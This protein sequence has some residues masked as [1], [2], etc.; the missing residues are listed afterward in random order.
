MQSA[1][2]QILQ[3]Y[4]GYPQF[5]P[6]QQS[7]IESV[8]QGKDVFGIMPTGGGKSLCYQVPALLLP[9]TALVV[10][11]LISLMEDQVHNLQEKG[12]PAVSI[13]S[14]LHTG[15]LNDIL[16]K[17]LSGFYKVMYCSPERLH[18]EAF[19]RFA[20]AMDWS[21]FVIDE[22]H[23]ISQW[24][25]D[26][27][28]LYRQ[29]K[30]FQTAYS[31]QSTLALTASATTQVQQDIIEQLQ[32]QNASIFHQSVVRENLSYHV[33]ATEH[34]FQPLVQ[35]LNHHNSIVYCP[36][37]K[38]TENIANQ[39][40]QHGQPAIAYHA[41]LPKKVRS[42]IQNQWITQ[43][44]TIICATNA[45]GMGIDKPNVREVIH[46]SPPTSLEAYYQEAGRAGRDGKLAQATL[47]FTQKDIK[48]LE[49]SI[50]HRFPPATFIQQCYNDIANHLEIGIGEGSGRKY[51]FSIEQF[52]HRYKHP[53]LP[54]MHA[55]KLLESEGYWVWQQD[56]RT[57]HS[58]VFTSRHADIEQLQDISSHLY[59]LAIQLLRIYGDIYRYYTKIDIATIARVFGSDY[60]SVQKGLIKLQQLGI[61]KYQP[62]QEGSSL[63]WFE[64]RLPPHA[65]QINAKRIVLLKEAYMR[66]IASI[67]NYLNNTTDCR[68][69]LI[70]Q[71]FGEDRPPSCGHCDNCLRDSKPSSNKNLKHEIH[72]YIKIALETDLKSITSAFSEVSIDLVLHYIQ[73]LSLEGYIKI[74]G[75]N[76]IFAK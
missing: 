67:L 15:E 29:I 55:I 8:L 39:L 50:H 24:G 18:S 54:L 46:W 35:S 70:A 23:C 9:G 52:N 69:Q 53:I 74:Q 65:F 45:F 25:H 49:E 40:S 62:A 72:A 41:G 37:R 4:W 16:Q 22:A 13:H 58:A 31:F 10:S 28:P 56:D 34:K 17:A 32:L 11:P 21:I 36:T 27:R 42:S 48:D 63:Y 71:Y 19:T 75:T 2:L 64:D 59:E 7:I 30:Q 51:I 33:L 14:G 20:E 76:V 57:R 47:L 3:K 43:D 60:E 12:I 26:F 61:L 5:R 44:N 6:L 1:M 68:S 73:Q 38:L 66:Q